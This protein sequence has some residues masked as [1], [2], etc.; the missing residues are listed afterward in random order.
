MRSPLMLIAVIAAP[1]ALT[2]CATGRDLPTYREEMSKLDADCIARGGILTPSGMQ[3]GR[4]QAD[5]VCK[6]AGGATRIP[7]T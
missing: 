3:T 1:L 4:P 6:I 7:Q 5:Y 2:A